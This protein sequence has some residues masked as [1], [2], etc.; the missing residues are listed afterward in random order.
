M[1]QGKEVGLGKGKGRGINVWHFN[2]TSDVHDGC[3]SWVMGRM[4]VTDQVK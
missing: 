1:P 3:S 2:E 4:T